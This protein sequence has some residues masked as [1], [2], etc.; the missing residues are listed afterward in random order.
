MLVALELKNGIDNMLKHF[1]TGYTALL[2]YMAYYDEGCICF[3]GKLQDTGCTLA[4]LG[5]T[6]GRR[7]DRLG[8]YGLD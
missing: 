5:Y 4:Y 8:H 7:F 2:V 6:A 3:L 1:R